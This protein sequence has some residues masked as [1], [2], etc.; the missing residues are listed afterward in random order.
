M[1]NY[2][3][4]YWKLPD[5][6][7]KGSFDSTGYEIDH[8]MEFSISGND[9]RANLQALCLPC[10][11]EKTNRFNSM[12]KNN[13]GQTLHNKKNVKNMSINFNIGLK[14]GLTLEEACI[15]HDSKM[16][17]NKIMCDSLREQCMYLFNQIMDGIKRNDNM[18]ILHKI[19]YASNVNTLLLLNRIFIKYYIKPQVLTCE[20]VEQEI[21]MEKDMLENFGFR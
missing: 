19:K 9:D 3:C 5:E 21:K 7:T 16:I 20:L 14:N 1:E 13:D 6:N 8:I 18:K 2:K 4:P 10:H 11:R 15:L 17:R 12:K